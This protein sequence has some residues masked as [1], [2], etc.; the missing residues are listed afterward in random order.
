MN[1]RLLSL[2]VMRGMTIAGMLLVNNPGSWGHIYPPLE[3]AEWNGLTPTDLVFPFFMF[4]MGMSAYMSLRKF[5][6]KPSWPVIWKIVRRTVLLFAV[7]IG[8]ILIGRLIRGVGNA[9]LEWSKVFDFNNIRILGVIPRLAICYGIGS[10]VAIFSGRRLIWVIVVMLVAYAIMLIVG[11]GYEFSERNVINVVDRAVLGVNHMYTDTVNG[12]ELKFDPEGFL[13]TLPSIAHTLI[14][15]LAGKMIMARTDNR[16][17]VLN[18]MVMG[19]VLTFCGFLFAYGLPLNK[20]IWSPTFVLTTCGLASL[21]LGLLIWIIDINGRRKWC[22]FFRDFGVNPL[23]MYVWGTILSICFGAIKIADTS[24]HAYYYRDFL[25]PLCAG[26]ETMA[27][28]C[29]AVTF[30]AFVWIFAY[31]L[32]RNKIYIKI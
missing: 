26:D 5:D 25:I 24:L 28:C 13:S 8:I 7:G 32:Y 11:N 2:D 14:G 12:V 19:T 29:F 9:N 22:A 4:I 6:C 20:K 18:L 31:I 17:R 16:D 15:F 30:V 21:L 10:L 27:S 3:H 1:K 23:F